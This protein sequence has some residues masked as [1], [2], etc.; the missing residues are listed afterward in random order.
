MENIKTKIDEN[1]MQHMLPVNGSLF[2]DILMWSLMF[3]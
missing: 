3:S 1:D 2:K